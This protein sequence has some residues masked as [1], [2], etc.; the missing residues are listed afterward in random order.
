LSLQLSEYFLFCGA[1][2]IFLTIDSSLHRQ[3]AYNLANDIVLTMLYKIGEFKALVVAV[4]IWA[5]PIL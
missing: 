2:T 1:Y 5:S 4:I 3:V